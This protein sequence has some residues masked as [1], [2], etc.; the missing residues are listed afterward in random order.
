M[1]EGVDDMDLNEERNNS[2]ERDNDDGEEGEESELNL[3]E[4][5]RDDAVLVFDK[6][7]GNTLFQI[8]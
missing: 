7:K 5:E 4:P 2:N 3:I 8:T 1:F 6:H